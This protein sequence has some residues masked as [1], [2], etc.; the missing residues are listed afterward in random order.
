[1]AASRD[2]PIPPDWGGRLRLESVAAFKRNQ[3]QPSPGIGGRLRPESVATFDRN[4]HVSP[5]V[6]ASINAVLIRIY[7]CTG[8]NRVF[9]EWLDRLLLHIGKH[10]DDYLT[11]PLHHAKDGWPLFLQCTTAPFAFASA[12]ATFSSL[13]LHHLRLPLMTSNHIGF[14]AL[15]FI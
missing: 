14:V 9:D 7:P 10:V 2:A 6:Q 5:I 11:T 8:N 12:S 3:W 1:M 15:Y 4:T 13:G